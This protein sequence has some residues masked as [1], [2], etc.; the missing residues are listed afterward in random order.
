MRAV[1]LCEGKDDA[2]ILGAYLQMKLGF[3]RNNSI[4]FSDNLALKKEDLNLR[5]NIYVKK[6]KIVAVIGVG[7]KN[8]FCK[9]FDYLKKAQSFA[10]TEAI[11]HLFVL[12]DRDNEVEENI[13]AKIC[14]IFSEIYPNTEEAP[15][16]QNQKASIFQYQLRSNTH[17]VYCIPLV[18]PFD[19]EGAL[20]TI[21]MRVI[22]EES[23]AGEF[24]V[25]EANRYIDRILSD[26]RR[27]DYLNKDRM[28]LK[29][30]FSAV[31]SVTNPDHAIDLYVNL[32]E[33]FDWH[34]SENFSSN[35]KVLDQY[36]M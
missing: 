22:Q 8:R 11:T 34:S 28:K 12:H 32:L 31:L 15:L 26:D 33:S 27:G 3:V 13:L 36:F 14:A 19:Q 2:F 25:V 18:I 30:R 20:E 9:Y 17:S 7:G 29:A 1:V 24:V 21:L 10:P 5:I 6:E 35:F 23:K 16:L 4:S